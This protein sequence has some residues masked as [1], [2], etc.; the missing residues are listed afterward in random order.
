MYA[1][2]AGVGT[3]SHPFPAFAET[4]SLAFSLAATDD[5]ESLD[6]DVL[7]AIVVDSPRLSRLVIDCESSEPNHYKTFSAILCSVLQRKQLVW[8]LES[9]KLQ[10]WGPWREDNYGII[11]SA[12]I[13]SVPTEHA[14]D[15][16]TITLSFA[17]QVEWILCFGPDEREVYLQKLTAARIDGGA[18]TAARRA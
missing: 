8:A 5:L 1:R 10:F 3:A 15:E 11:T 4:L 9:R 6:L 13:L 14:D 17:Q 2:Q 12:D 18:S 7:Q 16:I